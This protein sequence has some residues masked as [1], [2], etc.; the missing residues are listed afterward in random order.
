[1][2]QLPNAKL[3]Q[4]FEA[5]ARHC[6]VTVA[7]KEL[8][9]TQS[10][11]SRQLKAL[12][13]Q[14]DVRLFTREKN[15]LGLTEAGRALHLVLDKNL[16]EINACITNIQRGVP[17]RITVK[18][19]PSLTTRW[20]AP[21]LVRFYAEA[22]CSVSLYTDSQPVNVLPGAYDCEICFGH[23]NIPIFNSRVLFEELIQPA[24]SPKLLGKIQKYGIDSVPVLH[25]LSAATP[26]PYWE[27]W[28]QANPNS[29]YGP[30]VASLMSGMEFSTQE[31]AISAAV[32]GLGVVMVDTN[33]ASLALKKKHLITLAEPVT[34]PFRYWLE[35]NKTSKANELVKKF[36]AWLEKESFLCHV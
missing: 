35:I 8:Y 31:Q 33:I 28:M 10:A 12:E 32:E 30:S 11:L 25:T 2:P 3:L 24:C 21:R 29:P 20:L 9:I 16:S 26:L 19:P 22:R 36:C 4:A 15:K 14:L 34:T 5:V 17:R 27:F 18:A 6:S 23:S 7:S 1:M 13:A